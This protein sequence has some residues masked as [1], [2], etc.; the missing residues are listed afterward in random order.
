MLQR[1]GGAQGRPVCLVYMGEVEMQSSEG[2]SDEAP[3]G[4]SV[5]IYPWGA[6]ITKKRCPSMEASVLRSNPCAHAPVWARTATNISTIDLHWESLAVGAKAAHTRP[7]PPRVNRSTECFLTHPHSLPPVL[8]VRREVGGGVIC[9]GNFIRGKS[10][11]T[12]DIFG[13][14]RLSFSGCGAQK[15]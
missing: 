6:H 11:K 2:R 5:I 9:S 12:A 3:V 4:I 14:L 15:N 7:G 8:T 10:L 13:I 1:V